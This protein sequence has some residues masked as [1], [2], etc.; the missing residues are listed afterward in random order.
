MISR[1]PSWVRVPVLFFVIFGLMEYFV[2]SGDQPAI[3]AY[4][5]AQFF[6]VMVLLLLI[7]I[8][9]IIKSVENIMFHSL[10]DE[11]KERY[12]AQKTESS[13]WAWANN[14][15]NK[16]TKS[17]SIEREEEIILDHNYDGIKELNNV[18]PPWW[19][20]LFYITIIFGVV[21]LVRFHIVGEYDQKL[22]YEQEVAAAKIAIEEYKKNAK[23]LV[24]ANTVEVL[25]EPADLAAGE[26]IY[27][28][29]CVACHMADGGGGIGPNLTD[30]YWIL[31]GGIKNVFTIGLIEKY[32]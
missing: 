11:A 17:R 22:E 31:G 20:Y 23:D 21:Y 13:E 25:T 7:A 2:D 24:D 18:L 16:L 5:I 26:K 28:T 15:I 14:V 27:T 29:N 19:V 10:T 4:P 30:E 1:I 9:V 3:I 32:C 8:E 6:M 12:L